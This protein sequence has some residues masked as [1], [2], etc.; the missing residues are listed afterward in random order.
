MRIFAGLNHVALKTRDIDRSLAFYTGTLGMPEIM[1][2][3]Y[4]DGSLFLIYLKITD[5]QFIE[6]FPDGSDEHA[7]GP[8]ATAVNHFCL[9]VDNI[10]SAVAELQARG[11]VITREIKKGV[12]DNKQAWFEDPD[13]NRIEL[14]QMLPE[15]MQFKAMKGLAEGKP[16]L[17]HVTW[18]KP[19]A[20]VA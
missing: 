12:D 20:P 9:N 17:H 4:D 11:V 5:D 18:A 6:L 14:M 19:P 2:L 8:R 15:G 10:E 7:P 3:F 13:G 16:A 1:R